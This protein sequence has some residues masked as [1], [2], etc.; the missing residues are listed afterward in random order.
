MPTT[1]EAPAESRSYRRTVAALL[2]LALVMFAYPA[3]RIFWNIEIDSN[4]G[5]N[6]YYQLRAIAGQSLYHNESPLFLNNYPPLSFYLVGALAALIGDPMLAGRAVS[7]A[8]VV[9]IALSAAAIVRSAGGSRTDG[10]LAFATCLGL[11]AAFA[12]DYLGMNDPQLLGQ[13]IVV[14]GLAA[15]LGGAGTARQGMAVAALFA[16]GVLIKHNLVVVPLLVA[17]D[18]LV[19][20]PARARLAFF[21]TGLGLA[22]ASAAL[23]Y[24]LI[25]KTFFAQV[26]ASR[27]WDVERAFLITV[28][29]LARFQAPVALVVVALAV[30]RRRR[31][32][33]LVLAYLLA[34]L[35]A[36]AVFAGGANT[37]IN[38]FFDVSIALA[39]G[40]GLAAHYLAG[41]VAWPHATAL[42]ALLANA[43][44][45]FYAPLTLGRFGYDMAGDLDRREKLFNAD[46]AYLRALPDPVVCQSQ[47]L[48]FEAGK[49][50]YYDS[51]NVNQAILAG[52]FPA[53][54]LIE[55]LRR[56]AIPVLQISDGPEFST[57]DYPGVQSM[58]AR[59]IH[60]ADPVF[61]TLKR[62]YLV[63]RVGISGRFYRPRPPL[64]Q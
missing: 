30:F 4:E 5:W 52:H 12:T 64:P 46:V 13:A 14:A 33:G 32:A 51:F 10:G 16:V 57:D 17:V 22:A 59:Y 8:A 29:T 24:A 18:V 3:L 58:P 54:V 20:G 50:M 42:L 63:D 39:I 48:C 25:G 21:A 60:F 19:R 44:V 2:A 61:E 37:D 31:P 53:D 15:H 56:H 1:I 27:V 49:A 6:A 38:V 7:L 23:L 47:L 45:L 9:A 35:A 41:R 40:T 62:E 36:G 11:F 28:E 34:A 43:G 55:K 26:L